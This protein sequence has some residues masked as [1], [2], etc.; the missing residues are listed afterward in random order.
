MS[1][2]TA[3]R[4][5]SV[6]GGAYRQLAAEWLVSRETAQDITSAVLGRAPIV[7]KDMVISAKRVP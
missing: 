6:P 5:L 3:A 1:S 4:R 2:A 7:R